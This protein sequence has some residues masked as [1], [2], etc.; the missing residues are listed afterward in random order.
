MS[1]WK[2]FIVEHLCISW[3]CGQYPFISP[4]SLTDCW[5]IN[6]AGWVSAELC[7]QRG[8]S[9]VSTCPGGGKVSAT[10]PRLSWPLRL[11]K[12]RPLK[13]VHWQRSEPDHPFNRGARVGPCPQQSRGWGR[14]VWSRHHL[15]AQLRYLPDPWLHHRGGQQDTNCQV[16]SCR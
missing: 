5:K 11:S 12:R 9:T 4:P 6:M 1:S 16:W 10:W 13:H 2:C 8:L 14:P 7:S 3:F 15:P